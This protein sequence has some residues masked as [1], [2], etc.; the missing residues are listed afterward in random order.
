MSLLIQ[1]IFV[2]LSHARPGAR[3]GEVAVNKP[4]T[5]RPL[6]EARCLEGRTVWDK[7]SQGAQGI[8]GKGQQGATAP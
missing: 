6:H 8:A 2:T 5:A 7:Y 1:Q 4:D 3:C